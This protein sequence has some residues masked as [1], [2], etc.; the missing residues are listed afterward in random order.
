MLNDPN[1]TARRKLLRRQTE[2]ATVQ[3]SIQFQKAHNRQ[4]HGFFDPF[5][6]LALAPW[7][8]TA[9]SKFSHV[10]KERTLHHCVMRHSDSIFFLLND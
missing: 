6:N 9:R 4:A 1:Q 2:P 8:S 5:L 10:I 7:A 3:L